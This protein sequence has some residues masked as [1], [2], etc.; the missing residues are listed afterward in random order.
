MRTL[1]SCPELS[2]QIEGFDTH[3][4]QVRERVHVRYRNRLVS[5]IIES[6]LEHDDL[7]EINLRPIVADETLGEPSAFRPSQRSDRTP[8]KV[9][10]RWVDDFCNAIEGAQ[11][12]VLWDKTPRSR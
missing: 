9:D 3:A 6:I 4:Y 12:P 10:P 2:L 11:G 5:L 7:R 1:F 8:R